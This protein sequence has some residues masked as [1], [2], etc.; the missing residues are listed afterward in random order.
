VPKNEK[1]I[2][3]PQGSKWAFIGNQP[4]IR[5]FLFPRILISGAK[6]TSRQYAE[7]I[8]S[9]YFIEVAGDG[10]R[11][12]WPRIDTSIKSVSFNESTLIFYRELKIISN[13]NQFKI[14]KIYF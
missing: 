6:I 14:Y 7:N 3:P 12:I 8:G 10:K 4:T 11:E 2:H 13:E 1:F 5:Y 9:A